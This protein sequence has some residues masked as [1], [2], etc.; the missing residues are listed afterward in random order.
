[1][2]SVLWKVPGIEVAE[3]YFACTWRWHLLD[4]RSARR[5]A[6]CW[7]E[8][9]VGG[10]G[11]CYAVWLDRYKSVF[12]RRLCGS[13]VA[14]DSITVNATTE[15]TISLC[16]KHKKERKKYEIRRED[17]ECTHK[18]CTNNN[19]NS[20]AQLVCLT[21]W[22]TRCGLP[23][24]GTYSNLKIHYITWVKY[25]IFKLVYKLIMAYMNNQNK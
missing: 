5:H 23:L 20:C 19:N 16:T 10:R 7:P 18:V 3:R 13:A 25:W 8:S 1:V 24:P 17:S 12:C 6:V 9:T 21:A 22:A 2:P 11:L 4:V 14:V 15:L